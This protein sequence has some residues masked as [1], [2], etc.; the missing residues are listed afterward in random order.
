VKAP[1]AEIDKLNLKDEDKKDLRG[2]NFFFV[3][4][5]MENID[6]ADLVGIQ[7]PNL[8]PATRSGG[9]PGSLFGLG[10]ISVAGCE[11]T[12]F[13]PTDFYTKGARYDKCKLYFGQAS[14][15]LT[16][17]TYTNQ[18]YTRDKGKSIIWEG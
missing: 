18:P 10:E 5:S 17:L 16:K 8:D 2:K 13:S 1:D 6:G 14:D 3:H 15:P 9:W 4:M 12:T 11:D 7:A